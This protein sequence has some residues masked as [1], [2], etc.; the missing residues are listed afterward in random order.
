MLSLL[1]CWPPCWLLQQPNQVQLFPSWMPPPSRYAMN[2]TGFPVTRCAY[3][4]LVLWLQTP[5]GAAGDE[6]LA[7]QTPG[8]TPGKEWKPVPN[9]AMT[10]F[11]KLWLTVSQPLFDQLRAPGLE[12]TPR[13]KNEVAD[14]GGS[15]CSALDVGPRHRFGARSVSMRRLHR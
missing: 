5:A 9:L 1:R 7:C 8:L 3:D 13:R 2:G 10:W 14:V 11:G 6:I 12:L 15:S 4:G